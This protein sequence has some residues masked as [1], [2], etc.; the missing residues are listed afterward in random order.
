MFLF[1]AEEQKYWYETLQ[2]G[3]D[4]DCIRCYECRKTQQAIAT[5]RARYEELVQ[6]ADRSE[7]ETLEL[8]DCG[9]T[10][11]EN[12]TFGKRTIE[13]VRSWLNSI[14][15]DSEVRQRRRFRELAERAAKQ[16]SM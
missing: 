7:T 13:R 6:K 4:S 14:P 5:T 15:A 11:M 1:F 16:N 12:R 3:L 8:A 2:F 9:L 10:L